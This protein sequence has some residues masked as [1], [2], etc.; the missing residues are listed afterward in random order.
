MNVA[1]Y[2][3]RADV[4]PACV[5]PAASTVR[6]AP[7]R[8]AMECDS[9]SMHLHLHVRGLTGPIYVEVHVYAECKTSPSTRHLVRTFTAS[10]ECGCAVDMLNQHVDSSPLDNPQSMVVNSVA[11]HTQH[12]NASG[13]GF[14]DVTTTTTTVSPFSAVSAAAAVTVEPPLEP[15]PDAHVDMNSHDTAQPH[16][17]AAAIPTTPTLSDTIT[18][19]APIGAS[20]CE[21]PV[22]PQAEATLDSMMIVPPPDDIAGSV[23]GHN[24]ST[25]TPTEP[26]EVITVEVATT[27]T[28]HATTLMSPLTATTASAVTTSTA[29]V[30]S[31]NASW[32]LLT[33]PQ[34]HQRA[35]T[36]CTDQY[37]SNV[38]RP[39]LHKQLKRLKA[40]PDVIRECLTNHT[41]Y[42]KAKNQHCKRHGD[43]KTPFVR[44]RTLKGWRQRSGTAL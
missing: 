44:K 9:G 29:V 4:H 42:R 38:T 20:V 12:D 19:P 34:Q 1:T 41:T 6:C 15:Q 13:T 18:T 3:Q 32:V 25:V 26:G 33:R 14:T 21:A 5:C 16:N 35:R 43:D 11:Q 22:V 39:Q 2:V 31:A 8:L 30:V 23:A 27:P 24:P 10:G 7:A 40:H 37:F 17:T 28:S 36:M